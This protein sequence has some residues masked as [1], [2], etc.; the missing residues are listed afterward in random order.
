MHCH[1]VE[2]RQTPKKYK[3]LKL[4]GNQQLGTEQLID[5]GIRSIRHTSG[6][7]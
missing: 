6:V 2:A 7:T 5:P 4:A 1:K 3:L